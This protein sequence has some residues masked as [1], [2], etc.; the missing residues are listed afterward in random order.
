MKN[1]LYVSC[2]FLLLISCKESSSEEKKASK[3][4]TILSAIENE[5]SKVEDDSL[6]DRENEANKALKNQI[7][8]TSKELLPFLPELVN[9]H[10]KINGYAYP[11]SVQL[12]TGSY[13][14]A[15]NIYNFSI[16]D[17]AGS[18]A[19]VRNFFYS[20]KIKNQ[21]PPQTEYIFLERD[22]YKT[23]AFMQPKIKRNQISFIYNNRFLISIEGPDS[24]I[25][26][27]S[28][29]DFENLKKLDQIN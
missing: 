17:G 12:V 26:L 8:F 14:S 10:K 2:F 5:K 29:I 6:Q 25:V 18:K 13:G 1:Y 3:N 22:G 21:G 20:Y 7:A 28:Y 16:E 24:D 11:D 15:E 4:T 9:N 23:I 19:I 27:W